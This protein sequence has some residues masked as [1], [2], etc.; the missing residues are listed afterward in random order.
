YTKVNAPISGRIGRSN[1][2]AGA[3]LSASQAEPLAVIQ[4]L[5]PIYVNISQSADEYFALKRDIES[6]RIEANGDGN[7]PVEL[8]IPGSDTSVTGELL[9]SE[10]SVDES[11]GSIALRALVEN[12]DNALLPGMFVRTQITNGVMRNAIL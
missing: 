3:L 1:Y 8:S 4:Q 12:P 10:V 11:T 9:F 5:D 7:P 2:T 6:G